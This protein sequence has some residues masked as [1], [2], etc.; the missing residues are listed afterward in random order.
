MG[1][2]MMAINRKLLMVVLICKTVC[3]FAT[4][5]NARDHFKILSYNVLTGFQ[6]NPAQVTVFVEW[7]KGIR[8]DMVAMQ[9]LSTFTQDSL[10]RL[11]KRYGTEIP[12]MR[13][14]SL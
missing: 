2:K 4:G 9:E 14:K 6:K 10:E 1:F 8:P 7:V 5:A 3:L 11:A 12:N 13:Y